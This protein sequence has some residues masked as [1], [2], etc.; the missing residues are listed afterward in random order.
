MMLDAAL[1]TL[2]TFLKSISNTFVITTEIVVLFPQA[3][4]NNALALNVPNSL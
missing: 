4:G 1:Q 3:Q 2:F